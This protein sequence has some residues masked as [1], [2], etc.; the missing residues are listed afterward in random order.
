M[1]RLKEIMRLERD[2]IDHTKPWLYGSEA[3]MVKHI[4]KHDIQKKIDNGLP[5]LVLYED[6]Q[7][8]FCSEEGATGFQNSHFYIDSPYDIT[9]NGEEWNGN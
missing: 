9:E 8:R 4:I 2:K 6:K 3:S 7:Y 1:R 5:Y